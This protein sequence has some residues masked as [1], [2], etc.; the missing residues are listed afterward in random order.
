MG[1][2]FPIG[3]F[4]GRRDIFE[5]LDHRKHPK[6]QE[7]AF[8]GGTFTGNPVSMVAGITTLDILKDGKV[9]KRI[10]ALGERIREGLEDI[11]GRSDVDAAITGVG[12]TFGIH[13]QREV[14]TN[15]RDVTKNDLRVARGFYAHMLSRSI[16]YV[17]RE[18]PISFI[19]E[20]HTDGDIEEYLGAAGEFFTSYRP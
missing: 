8:H 9:Y 17:G 15:V 19:G 3:A 13:F 4:C 16:A 2:G 20:P 18:L 7:R 14:P 5:R 10:D 11:I 12:S 1:G 6:M